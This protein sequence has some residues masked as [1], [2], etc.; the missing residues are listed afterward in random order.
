MAHVPPKRMNKGGKG[1]E[2]ILKD[3]NWK[4]VFTFVEEMMDKYEKDVPE[5]TNMMERLNVK[6]R[7]RRKVARIFSRLRIGNVLYRFVPY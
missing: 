7:R 5:V 1:F 3:L 6:T 2:R 4:N